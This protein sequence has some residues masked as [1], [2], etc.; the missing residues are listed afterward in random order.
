MV[1]LGA[2]SSSAATAAKPAATGL[3]GLSAF[4]RGCCQPTALCPPRPPGCGTEFCPP[5][6]HSSTP[7]LV[8][9]PELEPPQCC[10]D[11]AVPIG[12][13]AVTHPEPSLLIAG[14]LKPTPEIVTRQQRLVQGHL[15]NTGTTILP[16]PCSLP[17]TGIKGKAPRRGLA[18]GSPGAG[19]G[20]GPAAIAA[21]AAAGQVGAG[22]GPTGDRAELTEDGAGPTGTGVE[23]TEGGARPTRAGVGHTR[24]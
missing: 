23:P 2:G 17:P 6:L 16:W 4:Q 19:Q 20:W 7:P 11:P 14:S 5:S 10:E 3:C 8:Q 9:C 15:C 22:A 24:G 21:G 13:M 18:R 1:Q 12:R